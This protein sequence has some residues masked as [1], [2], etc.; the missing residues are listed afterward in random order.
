M[1]RKC[2]DI[3][4]WA[5]DRGVSSCKHATKYCKA[6][7]YNRKLY[8]LYPA[9]KERDTKND[10]F[11][12]TLNKE[13]FKAFVE[14]R[15]KPIKRFRFNTRGEAFSTLE[16]INRI[17]EIVLDNPEILFWIPTR[18]WRNQEI[19]KEIENELFVCK[20]VRVMASLDPSNGIEEIESLKESG[21]ST[22]YFGDNEDLQDRI[23]CPKTWNHKN[24]AC[25]SCKK[26]CF[27]KK[28][29]DVHLKKH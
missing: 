3:G 8:N 18:G 21:W 22:L 29:V 27:A 5:L 1:F 6:N 4:M 24:G 12:K 20:N 9:M 16:D 28:R 13:I 25:E 19:R 17:K 7:C 26:G 23:K 10:E 2:D 14:S 15:R 11:W